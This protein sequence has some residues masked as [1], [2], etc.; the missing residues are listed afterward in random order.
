[1]YEVDKDKWALLL[2]LQ[3]TRKAQKAYAELKRDDSSMYEEVK[4]AILKRYDI[5]DNSKD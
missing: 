5:N 4:S 2:A 1:M 3:L